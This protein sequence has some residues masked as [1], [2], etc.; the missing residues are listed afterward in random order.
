MTLLSALLT[1]TAAEMQKP[2]TTMRRAIATAHTAAYYAGLKERTGVLPKGLSRV[3]R[4]ELKKVVAEQLKYY[5]RFAAQAE[6]MS[7]GA[8][9]ARAQMYATSIRATYYGAHYPGLSQYPCDG[10]TR[11]LT[12]CKCDLDERDDGIHWV[13]NDEGCEDCQA[14]AEGGPYGRG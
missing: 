11:C 3:E 4:A 13:L 10:N 1:R 6:E 12:N 5:D 8:V 2:G 9:G 7:E 14:M